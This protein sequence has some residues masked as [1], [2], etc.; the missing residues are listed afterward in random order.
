MVAIR[1]HLGYTTRSCSCQK[2]LRR[3]PGCLDLDFRILGKGFQQGV[4]EGMFTACLLTQRGS[5][6]QTIRIGLLWAMYLSHCQRG[7]NSL[8]YF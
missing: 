5:Q 6:T 2:H 7:L 3:A 4:H 1:S 8:G